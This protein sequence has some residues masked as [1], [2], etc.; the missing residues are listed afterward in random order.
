[1]SDYRSVS[2]TCLA[3]LRKIPGKV[4]LN[5]NNVGRFAVFNSFLTAGDGSNTR[6]T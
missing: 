6:L 1:M 5:D 2:G 3:R 4:R